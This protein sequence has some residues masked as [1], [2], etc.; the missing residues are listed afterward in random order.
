ML[1][2]I[3]YPFINNIRFRRTGT[4]DMVAWAYMRDVL[5]TTVKVYNSILT[6]ATNDDQ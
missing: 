6:G 3:S 1:L 5:W 2:E 4:E